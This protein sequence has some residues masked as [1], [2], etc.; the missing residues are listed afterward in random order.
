MAE[1]TTT[2]TFIAMTAPTTARA[3]RI[4]SSAF[5]IQEPKSQRFENTFAASL[6]GAARAFGFQTSSIPPDLRET[7]TI[8]Y[9]TAATAVG[10]NSA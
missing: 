8:N 5:S 1:P 10:I 6:M 3:A 4:Y 7:F 9:F 2:I